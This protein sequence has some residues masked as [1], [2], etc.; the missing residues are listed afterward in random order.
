M[1]TD[2]HSAMAA[3]IASLRAAL[4][5][6]EA[7]ADRAASGEWG[8]AYT[9]EIAR[10]IRD[11]CA[12]ALA[13]ETGKSDETTAI[14]AGRKAALEAFHNYAAHGLD[15]SAWARETLALIAQHPY[16]TGFIAG[17]EAALCMEGGGR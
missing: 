2:S 17:L 12:A 5:H 7:R 10:E 9:R 13:G 6:I 14:I 8:F 11:A 3:E 1:S 15:A 4:T 16:R